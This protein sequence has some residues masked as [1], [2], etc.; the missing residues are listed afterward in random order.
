MIPYERIGQSW[1]W[2]EVS[3]PTVGFLLFQGPAK[4]SFVWRSWSSNPSQELR[5]PEIPLV[6]VLCRSKVHRHSWSGFYLYVVPLLVN[7]TLTFWPIITLVTKRNYCAWDSP[8]PLTM[9]QSFGTGTAA[10]APVGSLLVRSFCVF[11][12]QWPGTR[13]KS[14]VLSHKPFST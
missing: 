12:V 3:A 1:V 6:K 7:E 11:T 5:S 9:K 14:F 13:G 10:T 4:G 8:S 2:F